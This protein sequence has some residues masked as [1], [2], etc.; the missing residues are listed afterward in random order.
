MPATSDLLAIAVHLAEQA[1]EL[2][3]AGLHRARVTQSGKSNVTDLVTEIDVACEELIVAGLK[4]AFPQDG[5]MGEE[6]AHRQTKSGITWVIDPLDGTVNYVR[7]IAVFGV[8]IA[9]VDDQGGLVGVVHD[10]SRQQTFAAQR[11]A[12]ATCNGSPIAP[13]PVTL[14]S[15]AVV[16]DGFSYDRDVRVRQARASVHIAGEVANIRRSGSAAL[17][18]CAVA[19]GRLD[20][21]AEVGT[22]PWD[23]AAGG[24]IV[25]EAGAWMA[26]HRTVYGL[27]GFIAAAAP[28]IAGEWEALTQKVLELTA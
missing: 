25:S 15:E 28:G 3:L 16:A 10:P 26:R 27:E 9:A 14:L 21:Y 23:V 19:C 4:D 13:S 20:A 6:G 12:G 17:D 22:K 2:Q 5:F 7:D 24:L 11:G 8:S 1:G 18:L